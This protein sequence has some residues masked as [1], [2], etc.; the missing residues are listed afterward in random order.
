M[1]HWKDK[2][3]LR[4]FVAARETLA[5]IGR[6]C[7]GKTV[8]PFSEAAQTV[9]ARRARVRNGVTLPVTAVRN[10]LACP[11]A[12]CRWARKRHAA[13][14]AART[15]GMLLPTARNERNEYATRRQMLQLTLAA[16]R[17]HAPVVI[18]TAFY[19][20]I[21]F[22]ELG[23]VEVAAG[24]RH[25]ADSKNGDKRSVPAHPRTRAS[26]PACATSSL[27]EPEST[28]QKGWQCA[29]RAVGMERLHLHPHPR[30]EHARLELAD[31]ALHAK[32]QPIVGPTRFVDAVQVDDPRLDQTAQLQQVV[33]VTSVASKPRG[34]EAQDGAD[35]AGAPP[36]HEAIE[37]RSGHHAA[38]RTA[39]VIVDDLHLRETSA[40]SLCHE[41]V[42]PALA[43][44]VV[45]DLRL[46][47][48]THIDDG[49]NPGC[50]Q[51]EERQLHDHLVP[52]ARVQIL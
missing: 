21:H 42:L 25:L 38:G 33:P 41:V 49:R 11:N 8:S 1:L 16:D 35:F 22:G 28:L 12:G 19:C 18:R 37:A 6:A 3:C 32:Q 26:A 45:L 44:Q 31:A 4:S 36:R 52:F 46:C 39:E 47:G 7:N 10:R 14:A 34:I 51:Q 15:A 13:R 5:A 24:A 29:R 50:L 20:G 17:H 30:T 27:I 23:R 43:P 9:N 40:A 48:L 2:G